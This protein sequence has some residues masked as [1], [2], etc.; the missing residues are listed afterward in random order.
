MHHNATCYTLTPTQ[1]HT[2]PFRFTQTTHRRPISTTGNWRKRCSTFS[3]RTIRVW[4]GK[5]RFFN[6]W[7][8][9]VFF[10]S[11]KHFFFLKNIC[12][13]SDMNKF[14]HI[15]T[16]TDTFI[17]VAVVLRYVWVRSLIWIRHDTF[18]NESCHSYEW[19][20][21]HTQGRAGT[22]RALH[23]TD[24]HESVHTRRQELGPRGHCL[25][26]LSDRRG[27]NPQMSTCYQIYSMQWP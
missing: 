26:P 17:H 14:T 2:H 27:K 4:Y 3:T 11:K 8:K 23:V 5:T 1:T 10:F 13:S 6:R 22:T 18:V 19:V 12:F 15:H 25:F 24:M 9:W 16:H 20:L 7:K 21:S